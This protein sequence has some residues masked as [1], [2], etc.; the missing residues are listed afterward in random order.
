MFQKGEFFLKSVGVIVEYNPFHNGHAFHLE[1]SKKAADAD[2]VIAAMSGNFLQRGEPALVSKWARAKMALSAGVDIVFEL[3]YK[4]ATQ[5]AE[6]FAQGAVSILSSAGCDSICFGSE[7]GNI[8][9]F[10]DTYFFMQKFKARFEE[11][12]KQFIKEGNSYPKALSLAFSSLSPDK[13]LID[14]SKPN[15][16]LGFQYLNACQKTCSQP[17]KMLTITRK[18]AGYHDENFTSETIASATSIRKALF[19]GDQD[20]EKIRSYLPSSTLELLL[21]YRWNFGGFHDWEIY[22]PLLKVSAASKQSCGVKGNL[23]GGRR[24]RK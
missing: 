1:E 12:V 5:Q 10:E 15:N 21:E 7:S 11:G 14:L 13:T 6:I 4:Y 19:S 23:R 24:N 18:N 3:P 2:I 16:I 8:N 20:L 22:W 9:A 17:P